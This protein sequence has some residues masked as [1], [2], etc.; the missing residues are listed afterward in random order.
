MQDARSWDRR[1]NG[2]VNAT[3]SGNVRVGNH[4][5]VLVVEQVTAQETAFVIFK[6]WASGS[7]MV[8]M[9]TACNAYEKFTD[10][11]TPEEREHFERWLR[12]MGLP[13]DDF[14]SLLNEVERRLFPKGLLANV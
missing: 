5:F 9:T 6:G 3:V 12:R 14:T 7:G 11:L 8:S 1:K 2:G 4:G 13:S 10:I